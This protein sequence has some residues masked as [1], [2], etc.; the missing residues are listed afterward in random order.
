MLL[1]PSIHAPQWKQSF[2]ATANEQRW[3]YIEAAAEKRLSKDSEIDT[4]L[5]TENPYTGIAW[6]PDAWFVLLSTLNDAEAASRVW[7][8]DAAEASRYVANRF[9][10]ADLMVRSGAAVGPAGMLSHII[11]QLGEVGIE[12]A[13]PRP[14]FSTISWFRPTRELYAKMPVAT[15]TA[16]SF[17]PEWFRR[18]DGEDQSSGWIDLTG[19]AKALLG[20]P[21]IDIPRGRWRLTLRIFYEGM[22]QSV[23]IHLGQGATLADGDA[24]AEMDRDGIY[25]LSTVISVG[26]VEAANVS[27]HLGR[28]SFGGRIRLL[29]GEIEKIE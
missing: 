19:R 20:G 23:L 5:V 15:R 8:S 29:G 1:T 6:E 24:L 14:G 7:I 11:P 28:S 27:L 16:A 22:K 18:A 2:Q 3:G 10:A 21:G 13:D 9:A 26:N 25:E 4:V 17:G 12:P